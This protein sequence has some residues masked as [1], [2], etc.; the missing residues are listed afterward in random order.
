MAQQERV[1]VAEAARRLGITPDAVRKRFHG[2]HMGGE[3]DEEGRIF[4]YLDPDTTEPRMLGE[5]SATVRLIEELREHN[6][7]LRDQ[8][9][10][11]REESRR[12]DH[13]LAA[14]LE[15]LPIIEAPQEA[16]DT[17]PEPRGSSEPVSEGAGKGTDQ[18]HE[19][20]QEPRSWWQRL[21]GA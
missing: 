18:S 10:E 5:D 15:R 3:R 17:P 8:L 21:F 2:G 7:F 14:A 4:V 9:R 16:P 1:T 20:D 19:S 13:L 11:E 12:K 6:A